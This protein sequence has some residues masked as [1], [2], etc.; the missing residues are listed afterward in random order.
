MLIKTQFEKGFLIILNP[1][2][3]DIVEI[4]VLYIK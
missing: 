1:Y 2:E 3:I 4:I